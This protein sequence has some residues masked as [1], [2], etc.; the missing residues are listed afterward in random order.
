MD[1]IIQKFIQNFKL[2]I[3]DV[4]KWSKIEHTR[5][6]YIQEYNN[7]YALWLQN[8]DWKVILT[9]YFVDGYLR[10]LTCKYYDGWCNSIQI[11]FYIWRADIL[12]PVFYQFCHAVVKPRTVNHMKFGY[13]YTGYQMAE[14]QSSWKNQILSMYQVLERLITFLF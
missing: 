4:S 9:I 11:H 14:Q 13:N 7:D 10:V 3:V 12:S 6:D 2:S 8:P 1:T 5:D